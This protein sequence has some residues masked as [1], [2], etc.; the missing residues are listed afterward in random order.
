MQP[1]FVTLP[2][3]DAFRRDSESTPMC[4]PRNILTSEARFEFLHCRLQR[5][6]RSDRAA[7]LTCTRIDAILA[8]ATIPIRIAFGFGGVRYRSFNADLP[9]KLIPMKVHARAWVCA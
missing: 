3:F 7:L 4:W 8:R 9:I 5:G 6:T 2:E 1:M